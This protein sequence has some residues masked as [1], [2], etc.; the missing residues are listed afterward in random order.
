MTDSGIVEVK[1]Q[2]FKN[3]A[4]LFEADCLDIFPKL[5]K[6]SVDLILCDPP[7][8]TTQ[9]KWDVIIPF[10]PM[11]EGIKHILKPNGVVVFTTAQPFTSQMVLSNP[12]W[13]KYDI[14][15]KKTIGSGQ[16]NIKRQPLRVHEHILIFYNKPGTY[17]EQKTKG[18]PYKITRKADAFEGN[19]GKQKNHT[20]TNDGFRHAQS[21]LEM[22]NPRIKGGHKTEK[23]LL[24]MERLIK[25]Y[26]NEDD[27]VLDFAMGH[28]TTGIG[29]FNTKR[30]FIGIEKTNEWFNKTIKRFENKINE[31]R[32]FN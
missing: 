1:F 22:S 30:N 32:L 11:W 9:N 27:I 17:N 7:Y 4:R 26:S 13:Y 20:K 3:N 16:L 31:N 29:C 5:E 25:T 24:L 18:T 19:Y 8:G 10:E 28:G 23:P 15:W 14:I 6:N 12:H 21:V 2:H